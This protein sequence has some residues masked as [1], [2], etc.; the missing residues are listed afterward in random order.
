MREGDREMNDIFLKQYRYRSHP[1]LEATMQ[2]M[3]EAEN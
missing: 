2:K 1:I 3:K